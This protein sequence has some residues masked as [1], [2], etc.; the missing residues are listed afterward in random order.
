MYFQGKKSIRQREILFLLPNKIPRD[1][2]ETPKLSLKYVNN[3]VI[4]L[5]IKAERERVF[6]LVIA[7]LFLTVS[8]LS[9]HSLAVI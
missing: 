8:R 1:I 4:K 5:K 3:S 9:M 6:F 2:P 7:I